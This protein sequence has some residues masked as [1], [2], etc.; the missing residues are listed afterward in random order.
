MKDHR[1]QLGELEDRLADCRLMGRLSSDPEIRFQSRSRAIEVQE[2][3]R[4]LR[5]RAMRAP[6][7]K[8]RTA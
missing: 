1:K 3:I 8:Q 2:Q 5:L 7:L 4:A 6:V